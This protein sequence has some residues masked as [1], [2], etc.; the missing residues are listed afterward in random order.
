[1]TSLIPLIESELKRQVS[2]LDQPAT[3]GFHQMLTYHLGWTGDG[4]GPEASGKRIRPQLLCLVSLATGLQAPL[5]SII[6]AAAAV[7]LVHNFS[8]VHDD[9][10]DNSPTRRGRETLWMKWGIPMAINAGDALFVLADQAMMDLSPRH[11]PQIVLQAASRLHDTCLTLTRGQYLDMSFEERKSLRTEEY[12][13]MITSKTAALLEACCWIGALLAGADEQTLRSY[14]DFGHA[15][16]MAFQIQDD[17]LG[18]WGE[19][20][21]TGKS[22]ASDLVEGKKSLPVLYG[23]GREEQFAARWMK[24]PIYPNEVQELAQLLRD[25]GACDYAQAQAQDWIVAASRNLEQANPQGEAAAALNDLMNM[26][27]NRDR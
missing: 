1:M 25:E 23:L 20:A 13:E 15:L 3:A 6:P 22:S 16:G 24:G 4:S 5:E 17:I 18:I 8:L 26:F 12:L 14:S 10:E 7:E 11:P 19:E 2:R 9:I 27:I 21:T